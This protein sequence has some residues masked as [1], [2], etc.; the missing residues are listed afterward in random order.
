MSNDEIPKDT[1]VSGLEL[2]TD[3]NNKSRTD[4]VGENGEEG[5]IYARALIHAYITHQLPIC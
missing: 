4:N 5:R 1:V 2:E 3:K